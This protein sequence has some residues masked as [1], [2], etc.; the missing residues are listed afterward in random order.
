MRRVLERAD[1]QMKLRDRDAKAWIFK[2]G[3]N[4]DKILTENARLRAEN[5]MLRLESEAQKPKARKKVAEQSTDQFP[6]TKDIIQAQEASERPP[7][8][9]KQV[10]RQDPAPIV[11]EAQEMIVV[12]LG[13]LREAKEM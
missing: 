5:E 6:R 9:R 3:D 11:E 8:R 13:R 1:Q 2:V 10:R 12:A 7:K 4:Y